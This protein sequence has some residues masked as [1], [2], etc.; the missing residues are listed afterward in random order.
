L[1]AGYDVTALTPQ[2]RCDLVDR[3][4]RLSQLEWT[5]VIGSAR[6]GLGSEKIAV[7]SL[8]KP[9]PAGISPDTNILAFRCFGMMPML[10]FRRHHVL[11]LIWLDPNGDI[12]DH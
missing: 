3:M 4:S 1:Q 2:Q 6:H 12:Y 7:S 5:Q 10:G 9:L 11:H 8:R